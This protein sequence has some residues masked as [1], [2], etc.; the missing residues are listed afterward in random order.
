MSQSI[1]QPISQSI[2]QPISKDLTENDL[3]LFHLRHCRL[4]TTTYGADCKKYIVV[5]INKKKKWVRLLEDNNAQSD[6]T[7][8]LLRI[9]HDYNLIKEI[10]LVYHYVLNANQQ[11][12]LRT[13]DKKGLPKYDS[14]ETYRSV[15]DVL[16]ENYKNIL[17]IIFP[18]YQKLTFTFGNSPD[19]YLE[20]GFGTYLLLRTMDFYN[21]GYHFI[22]I[23]SNKI[24]Y[25]QNIY[26]YPYT[27][28]LF[29]FINRKIVVLYL[30]MT[31]FLDPSQQLQWQKHMNKNTFALKIYFLHKCY[32]DIICDVNRK[33]KTIIIKYFNILSDAKNL[34]S[35]VTKLNVNQ[36]SNNMKYYFSLFRLFEIDLVSIVHFLRKNIITNMKLNTIYGTFKC[37]ST[38]HITQLHYL[39]FGYCIYYLIKNGYI[40]EPRLWNWPHVKT[41]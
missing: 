20:M 26:G 1:S 2:S 19:K 36:K 8:Y 5:K 3:G 30:K 41:M 24:H 25:I 21:I 35:C 40:K 34:I 10:F 32:N 31:K 27:A 12:Y 16:H 37:T 29:E 22:G 7:K 9:H 14:L 18:D 23:F 11:I 4:G 6:K 38:W 15:L 39:D 13:I 28:K 33:R 17:N